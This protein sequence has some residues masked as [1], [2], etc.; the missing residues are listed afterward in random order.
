M[1][2]RL[3]DKKELKALF[4]TL[5]TLVIFTSV[6]VPD[7]L[8]VFEDSIELEEK[9]D[10]EKKESEEKDLEEDFE[11]DKLVE[12]PHLNILWNSVS[13]RMIHSVDQNLSWLTKPVYDII[14]PPPEA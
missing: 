8:D 13:V 12:N 10:S 6:V 5:F 4:L 11:E 1:I 3:P 14:T 9:K 2:F 7:Y